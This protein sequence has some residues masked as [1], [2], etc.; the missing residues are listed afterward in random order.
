MRVHRA[1]S[2]LRPP[3]PVQRG[4]DMRG[5]DSGRPSLH[6]ADESE[7]VGAGPVREELL[8]GEGPGRGTNEE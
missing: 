8:F 2:G 6:P 1:L 5:G 3:S 7:A 4:P